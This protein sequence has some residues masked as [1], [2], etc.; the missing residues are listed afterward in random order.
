MTASTAK[1]YKVSEIPREL[2]APHCEPVQTTPEVVG[3]APPLECTAEV[4]NAREAEMQAALD[5]MRLGC[6][7]EIAHTLGDN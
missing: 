6:A 7:G 2:L 1:A 4:R 5:D 3:N